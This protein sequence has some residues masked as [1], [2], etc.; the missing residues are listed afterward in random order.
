LLANRAH[1]SS[2][3]LSS[4]KRSIN[5]SGR[6][7]QVELLKS[8]LLL[9]EIVIS[10][11]VFSLHQRVIISVLLFVIP[12]SLLH[13]VLIDHLEL[14]FESTH[15]WVRTKVL[16]ESHLNNTVSRKFS[17]SRH[18][19]FPGNLRVLNQLEK[20]IILQLNTLTSLILKQQFNTTQTCVFKLL[21]ALVKFKV[22]F[23]LFICGKV[24]MGSLNV[25]VG[26]LNE[27]SFVVANKHLWLIEWLQ[28]IIMLVE[29]SLEKGRFPIGVSQLHRLLSV[30]SG[31]Q[32]RE[33]FI[34]LWVV[35]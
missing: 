11:V 32:V 34:E 16:S 2:A 18:H 20:G 7:L 9:H 14:V 5:E 24:L 13:V 26:C 33:S 10:K 25:S 27:I 29:Q 30:F 15:G 21:Q 4:G 1:E 19:H 22:N 28:V 35:F 12:S 8:L 31:G 23:Y 17:S 3:E 6:L